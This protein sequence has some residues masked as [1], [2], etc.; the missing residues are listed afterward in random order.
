VPPA[1]SPNIP[2]AGPFNHVGG[3]LVNVQ[4]GGW[5][6]RGPDPTHHIFSQVG[7]SS[8]FAKHSGG[9]TAIGVNVDTAPRAYT[10]PNDP[11]P[12]YVPLFTSNANIGKGAT[13]NDVP[14]DRSI[15][16][17]GW[18]SSLTVSVPSCL[19]A[20]AA[21]ATGAVTTSALAIDGS[22]DIAPVNN[23]DGTSTWPAIRCIST[24]SLNGDGIAN[25]GGWPLDFYQDLAPIWS[26]AP[27]S[28]VAAN[29]AIAAILAALTNSSGPLTP[30]QSYLTGYATGK[31]LPYVL[32]LQGFLTRTA[33]SL[34]GTLPVTTPSTPTPTTP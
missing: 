27:P 34:A 17:L 6:V 21:P 19:K 1:L 30:L 26:P 14:L 32:G 12:V 10:V 22:G 7:D 18:K 15:D 5:D 33:T 29:A 13:V 8:V 23:G 28:V 3:P 9:N 25:F 24:G 4:G 2:L 16:F 11:W 20:V 31:V